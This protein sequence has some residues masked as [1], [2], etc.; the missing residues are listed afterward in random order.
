MNLIETVKGILA[1]RHAVDATGTA[2]GGWDP[3]KS[4][5]KGVPVFLTFV[6]GLLVA[7]IQADPTTAFTTIVDMF[8]VP[9]DL[10]KPLVAFLVFGW[11]F[12]RNRTKTLGSLKEQGAVAVTTVPLTTPPTN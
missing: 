9:V 11:G 6:L 10:A 2:I 4:L 3:K 8:G 12:W 1:V 7:Y 5:M